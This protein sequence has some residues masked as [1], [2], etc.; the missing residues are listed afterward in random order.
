MKFKP[1]LLGTVSLASLAAATGIAVSQDAG[2]SGYTLSVEGG[3]MFGANT[4]A[5]DKL[6]SAG[7]AG[8]IE[9]Q[10]NVSYRGSVAI[11]Q[12]IDESLDWKI[13]LG[14]TQ[15]VPSSTYVDSSGG[16]SS[17]Y[18][19]MESAFNFQTADLEI[20]FSPSIDAANVRL[21]GGLRGMHFNDSAD[22]LGYQSG[23]PGGLGLETNYDNEFIGAGPRVGVEGSMALG[24]S[25]FGLSGLLSASAIYGVQRATLDATFFSGGLSSPYPVPGLEEEW[26]TI[27]DIEAALGVDVY[28]ND[29]TTLTVGVRAENISGIS[30]LDGSGGSSESRF[31]YG[32]TVKLVSSF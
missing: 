8:E 20:G 23:G 9:I 10:D 15:Q 31:S 24:D 30:G 32:P 7:S 3:G 4:V 11:G 14:F 13:A 18:A 1:V 19:E 22:K 16:P 28:L 12:R 29:Q 21:F 17:G 25:N 27:L 2:P 26:G 5:E 6:G